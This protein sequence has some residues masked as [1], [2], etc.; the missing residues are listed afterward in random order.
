MAKLDIPRSEDIVP[1]K[2]EAY[3]DDDEGRFYFLSSKGYY[4]RCSRDHLKM[5]LRRLGYDHKERDGAL[6]EADTE[7]LRIVNEHSVVYAGPL[8]GHDQG[9]Q[10]YHGRT[11][12]VTSSRQLIQPAEIDWSDLETFMTQLLGDQDIH[13]YAW[14]KSAWESFRDQTFRPGPILLLAGKTGSG[15]TLLQ[16]VLAFIFGNRCAKPYRY[17][18]GA[19]TFNG[20]LFRGEFLI[21]GDDSGSTDIRVRR[22]MLAEL[23]QIAAESLHSCHSKG[24]DAITMKPFWRCCITAN[25]DPEEITVF[26]PMVDSFVDKCLL[27]KCSRIT[28]PPGK[29]H[30]GFKEMLVAQLP[31][32]LHFLENAEMPEELSD[33]RFGVKGWQHPELLDRLQEHAPEEKFWDI[34]MNVVFSGQAAE[35]IGTAAVLEDILHEGS[36]KQTQKNLSFSGACAVFLARL[37]NKDDGRVTRAAARSTWKLVKG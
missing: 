2:L 35:W 9:P 15:K 19:T 11:V 1:D 14:I 27:L 26:P 4:L 30:N 28:P 5:E 10:D 33:E 3:Y 22:K 6:S 37:A 23:K 12:L 16:E 21:I 20:D 7:I 13:V 17:F 36:P 31:G 25:E 34:V 32:L 18:S 24:E 29:A 8:A